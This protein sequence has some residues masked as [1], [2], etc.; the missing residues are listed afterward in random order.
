MASRALAALPILLLSPLMIHACVS[1]GPPLP[2]IFQ[3]MQKTGYYTS[4][5][6]SVRLLDSFYR[7][8]GLDDALAHITVAFAQVQMWPA[9][10]KA[11]WQTFTLLIEWAGVYTILM[12]EGSRKG[13][14][15][16]V[17]Q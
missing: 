15:G 12:L 17:F 5:D 11:W 2:A 16:S 9:D 6:V 3:S 7:I 8:P 13:N 14:R 10:E 4:G 1:F